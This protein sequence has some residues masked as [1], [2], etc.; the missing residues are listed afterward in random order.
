MNDALETKSKIQSFPPTLCRSRFVDGLFFQVPAESA[1]ALTG[2]NVWPGFNGRRKGGFSPPVRPGSFG[3][4]V[5]ERCNTLLFTRDA[6]LR[7]VSPHRWRW[8]I[9]TGNKGRTT[10]QA[11]MSGRLLT[12]RR[13]ALA[14]AEFSTN[15]YTYTHYRAGARAINTFVPVYIML[16]GWSRAEGGGGGSRACYAGTWVP[17]SPP[18]Y[19]CPSTTGAAAARAHIDP[20]LNSSVPNTP[21]NRASSALPTDLVFPRTI[22]SRYA[23]A[24][25]HRGLTHFGRRYIRH[26]L[27]RCTG[28]ISGIT[29]YFTPFHPPVTI[30]LPSTVDSRASSHHLLAVAYFSSI[31]ILMYTITTVPTDL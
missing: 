21:E 23:F 8:M 27:C 24:H 22:P 26:G 13:L 4:R 30:P 2:L 19:K 15:T 18:Y 11:F 9:D 12:R 25:T 10:M 3:A 16:D 7:A 31:Q 20:A 6:I 5:K 14:K 28:L 1:A 17:R 29:Y